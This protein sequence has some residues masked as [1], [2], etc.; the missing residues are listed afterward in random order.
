MAINFYFNKNILVLLGKNMK[1]ARQVSIGEV[2][3]WAALVLGGF[4]DWH[5]YQ[6][7]TFTGGTSLAGKKRARLR[8][9]TLERCVNF[10]AVLRTFE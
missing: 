7:G 9:G 4:S 5:Y 8:P 6:D 3:L 1:A 2:G 10:E